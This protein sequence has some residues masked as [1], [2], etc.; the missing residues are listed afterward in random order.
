M[1][2][3]QVSIFPF[4]V[5]TRSSQTT[6]SEQMSQLNARLDALYAL[7]EIGKQALSI[8]HIFQPFHQGIK[9]AVY[10]E[11]MLVALY[12]PDHSHI[13]IPYFIDKVDS[14]SQHQFTGLMPAR[15]FIE[16]TLTGYIFRRKQTLLAD[17]DKLLRLKASGA[18]S[19]QGIQSESWLGIPL[20]F[21]DQIL[22]VLVLQSYDKNKLY[23]EEDVAFL[24][25][26]SNQLG[27]ALGYD[28]AQT[29]HQTYTEQ[30]ED[31]IDWQI[32]ELKLI[33]KKAVQLEAEQ[34]TTPLSQQAVKQKVA[35]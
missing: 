8:P 35:H 21:Q 22:G 5:K 19:Y 6:E 13:H 31:L 3:S 26:A 2:H 9:K 34:Q 7:S 33:S 32:D 17:S 25:A 16:S 11:N 28:L 23:N 1:N 29:S 30:L 12:N 24:Q 4:T 20:I 10:A 14:D 27:A 18:I 15:D